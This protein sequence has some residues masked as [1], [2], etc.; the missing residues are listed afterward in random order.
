MEVGTHR[1]LHNL[2]DLTTSRF[3]DGF[4]VAESLLGL[5]LNTTLNLPHISSEHK[6]QR[7]ND[8]SGTHQLSIRWV[9]PN[10]P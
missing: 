10:L 1:S 4:Q 7:G 5:C 2:A 6:V 8:S 3:N 9:Q